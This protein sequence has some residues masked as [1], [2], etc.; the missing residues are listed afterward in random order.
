[1]AEAT[2][3]RRHILP[4]ALPPTVNVVAVTAAWLLTGTFVVE[5]VFNYPGLGR[6]AVDAIADRDTDLILALT[7][8]GLAVFI[9]ASFLADT[10]I[11]LLD[12]R[13]RAGVGRA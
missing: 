5:V 4:A 8:L 12:P 9:T 13:V 2:V 1:V 10:V 11:R 3:V 7:L 6:L